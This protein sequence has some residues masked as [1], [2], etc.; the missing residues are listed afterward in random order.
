MINKRFVTSEEVQEDFSVSRAKAYSM[1]RQ[2]NEELEQAGYLVVPGRVSRKYYLER[3]YGD[4][5]YDGNEQPWFYSG[6]IFFQDHLNGTEFEAKTNEQRRTRSCRIGYN[7]R[8]GRVGV[9]AK[10]AGGID[11]KGFPFSFFAV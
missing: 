10:T 4:K 2:L 5:D 6:S 3:T 11:I 8:R 1:I 7:G 9:K